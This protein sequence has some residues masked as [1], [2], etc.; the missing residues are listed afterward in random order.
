MTLEVLVSCMHQTNFDIVKNSCINTDVLI[1]NQC[2]VDD[3][4][5]RNNNSGFVERMICTR[6]RGLSRSRNAAIEHARGDIC[7]IC[8]DDE[9]L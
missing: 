2:N 6:E 4:L 7:L 9:V 5:E 3:Y 1:V 8:D